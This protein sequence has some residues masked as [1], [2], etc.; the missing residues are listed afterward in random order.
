MKV[1]SCPNKSSK[2]FK[3]LNS[4]YGYAVTMQLYIANGEELPSLDEAEQMI[5]NDIVKKSYNLSNGMLINDIT[6]EMQGQVVRYLA[7]TM[8]T[9]IKDAKNSKQAG[10]YE[11]IAVDNLFN[12]FNVTKVLLENEGKTN[13]QKYR[14]ISS[15]VNN[16]NAFYRLSRFY[17]QSNLD[18]NYSHE[19]V[20]DYL[21]INSEEEVYEE[22]G[23]RLDAR[24]YGT[25]AFKEFLSFI[26]YGKTFFGTQDYLDSD[27]I[28]NELKQ[29]CA[30]VPND[31]RQ[32]IKALDNHSITHPYVKTIK[33]A[34]ATSPKHIKNQFVSLI[35]GHTIKM[36]MVSYKHIWKDGIPH[37]I[38][39]VYDSNRTKSFK[40][41]ANN[42]LNQLYTNGNTRRNNKK[43]RRYFTKEARE[44]LI[45]L[46]GAPREVKD[47]KTLDSILKIIGIDLR[48]TTLLDISE[49][50]IKGIKYPL[51]FNNNAPIGQLLQSLKVIAENNLSIE[52]SNLYSNFTINDLA[53]IE[54]RYNRTGYTETFTDSEGNLIQGFGLQKFLTQRLL[55]LK[56]NPNEVEEYLTPFNSTSDILSQL[57]YS[58][59]NSISIEADTI[60]LSYADGINNFDSNRS[61]TKLKK[62]DSADYEKYALGLFFNNNKKVKG[63]K[64]VE[65]LLPPFS[66]K[67]NMLKLQRIKEDVTLVNSQTQKGIYIAA[68]KDIATTIANSISEQTL[69]MLINKIFM[70]EYLRMVAAADENTDIKAFEAGKNIFYFIP[71]LNTAPYRNIIFDE[72]GEV[73]TNLNEEITFTFPGR[74]EEKGTRLEFV[75]RIV[76]GMMKQAVKEKL[77][78]WNDMGITNKNKLFTE[79]NYFNELKNVPDVLQ[80]GYLAL[81]YEIANMISNVE[82]FQ[83]FAGDPALYYKKDVDNTIDNIYKRLSGLIAPGISG[84]YESKPTVKTFFTQ[85]RKIKSQAYE[86]IK[87]V[88]GEEDAMPYFEIESTDSHELTTLEEHIDMLHMLGRIDDNIYNSIKTKIQTNRGGDYKL[89]PEEIKAALVP[90]K[91]VMFTKKVYKT[92]NEKLITEEVHYI[93]SSRFPLIPQLTKGF[94]IDK[95]RIAMEKTKIDTLVYESGHKLGNKSMVFSIFDENGDITESVDY[96]ESAM[97]IE[98]IDLDRQGLRIQQE[99]PIKEDIDSATRGTQEGKLLFAYARNL[100]NFKN[101]KTGRQLEKEYDELYGKLFKLKLKKLKESLGINQVG[102]NINIE[103]LQNILFDLAI[104]RGF[105]TAEIEALSLNKNGTDFKIPF[106]SLS[107]VNKYEELLNSIISNKLIKLKM[108]G[109]SYVLGPGAGWKVKGGSALR[110]KELGVITTDSYNEE[111]GLQPM[112]EDPKTGEILP[113]QIIIPF[114]YKKGK[115]S[116]Y[117]KEVN[118]RK[119]I[120]TSKLP[121]ELLKIFGFR[122]PSSKHSSFNYLEVVGFFPES[123]TQTIIDN[124]VLIPDDIVP[125]TGA[126][127]DVDK[128]FSYM[129]K[130]KEVDGVFVKDDNEESVIKNRLLDI[131]FEVMS[132][133]DMQKHI[134]KTVATDI[135]EKIADEIEKNSNKKKHPA[136]SFLTSEYNKNKFLNSRSAK[137]G[138]GVFSNDV[139]FHSTVVEKETKNKDRI[140]LRRFEEVKG[141]VVEVDYYINFGTEKG[142]YLDNATTLDGTL[143]IAEVH[144]QFQNIALDDENIGAVKKINISSYTF[145][146]I[147]LL[148]QLGFN[149]ETTLYFINQPIIKDYIDSLIKYKFK[150]DTEETSSQKAYKDIVNKYSYKENEQPAKTIIDYVGKNELK[151]LLNSREKANFLYDNSADY[152]YIQHLILDKFIELSNV[153]LQLKTIKSTINTDSARIKGST[154]LAESKLE[155]VVKLKSLSNIVN[156]DRIIGEYLNLNSPVDSKKYYGT[157]NKNE[158]FKIPYNGTTYAIKPNTLIGYATMYGLTTALDLWVINSKYFNPKQSKIVNEKINKVLEISGQ[159]T[160]DHYNRAA[161]KESVWN[162]IKSSVYSTLFV[163]LQLEGKSLT[164]IR[165]ELFVDEIVEEDEAVTIYNESLATIFSKIRSYEQFQNN[166]FIQ[167]LYPSND[168][169]IAGEA[170]TVLKYNASSKQRNYE[171]QLVADFLDLLQNPK[172]IGKFMIDGKVINYTTRDFVEKFILSQY[173]KGGLQQAGEF[174]KYI[175]I[176]L[177]E[178]MGYVEALED[179]DLFKYIPETSIRFGKEYLGSTEVQYM[180][181]NP[182]LAT[183]LT[184]NLEKLSNLIGKTVEDINELHVI[185]IPNDEETILANGLKRVYRSFESPVE[186]SLF[187]RI[188]NDEASKGYSLFMLQKVDN[189]LTYVRIPVLGTKDIT[190]TNNKV[191]IGD[192]IN[193]LKYPTPYENEVEARELEKAIVENDV[194]VSFNDIY[195]IKGKQNDIFNN[196]LK[197]IGNQTTNNKFKYLSNLILSIKDKIEIPKIEIDNS[198]GHRGEYDSNTNIIKINTSLIKTQ[199]EFEQVVLEEIIHSIT[200]QNIKDGGENYLKL[201]ELRNTIINM[202]GKDKVAKVAEKI[203]NGKPL[204]QEEVDLYYPLTDMYEFVAAIFTNPKFQDYLHSKEYQTDKSL[205]QR[206]RDIILNILKALGVKQNTML[207]AAIIEATPLILSPKN[208]KGKNNPVN[209]SPQIKQKYT[210]EQLNKHFKLTTRNGGKKIVSRPYSVASWINENV[211]NVYAS[212]H[213]DGRGQIVV[214]TYTSDKNLS[215]AIADSENDYDN[216]IEFDYNN[217]DDFFGFDENLVTEEEEELPIGDKLRR[218]KLLQ[219]TRSKIKKLEIQLANAE[220]DNDFEKAEEINSKISTLQSYLEPLTELEI[221]QIRLFANRDLREI[222]D[223]LMRPKL[224]V[225]NILYIGDIID[226]WKNA[227]HLLLTAEEREIDELYKQFQKFEADF[228]RYENSI[229][230]LQEKF[231]NSYIKNTTGKE[232][233]INEVF[234]Y[235]KDVDSITGAN[236]DISRI[237]NPL[238]QTL[239]QNVK[240]EN[241]RARQ[242]A[243]KENE[244]TDNLHKEAQK[245]AR[246]LGIDLNDLFSQKDKYGRKTGELVSVYNNNWYDKIAQE[247]NYF[248]KAEPKDTEKAV[249]RYTTFLMRNTIV[250]DTRLLFPDEISTQYFDGDLEAEKKKHIEEVISIIGE[251]E[252]NVLYSSL[253]KK[254]KKYLNDLEI[255]K[256]RI[257]IKVTEKITSTLGSIEENQLA[258]EEEYNKT[259][260]R[261]LQTFSPHAYSRSVNNGVVL[262]YNHKGQ[263]YYRKVKGD[264]YTITIPRKNVRLRPP[265]GI[266]TNVEERTSNP[267]Q[268]IGRAEYGEST[269]FYDDSFNQ[270]KD[271]EAI[272]AYYQRVVEVLSQMRLYLPESERI[273]MDENT[274]PRIYKDVMTKFMQN[275]SMAGVHGIWDAVS[276]SFGS[277]QDN[278]IT[279]TTK[280]VVTDEDELSHKPKYLKNDLKDLNLYIDVAINEAQ[281]KLGRKLTLEE[282]DDIKSKAREE[283]TNKYAMDI[284]QIIQMYTASTIAYKHKI[285]TQDQV[286]IARNILYRMKE[287]KTTTDGQFVVSADSRDYDKKNTAESFTGMKLSFDAFYKSFYGDTRDK[288]KSFD[289]KTYTIK[290]RKL[291]SQ[292]GKLLKSLEKSYEDGEIDEEKYTEKKEQIENRLKNIGKVITTATLTDSIITY[293]QLKGMGWNFYS[294]ISNM[295]FGLIS[296]LIESGDG[297]LYGFKDL[298][299]ANTIVLGSITKNLSF[300]TLNLGYAAKVRALMDKFDVLKDASNELYT[301]GKGNFLTTKLKFLSPYQLQ[302]RSEYL[303]QAP[304]LVAMM[305]KQQ[306]TDVN[307]NSRSLWEAY[308][309]DGNWK[310]DEFGE[311]QEWNGDFNRKDNNTKYLKFKN[312]VDQVIKRNHGNYDP[313]SPIYSKRSSIGRLLIQFKTW[314]LEGFANRF[315]GEKYD[316]VLEI[317]RR[318]RYRDF[319]KV[320]SKFQI[321]K[322]INHT[323]LAMVNKEQLLKK[324]GID[325]TYVA[326][327]RKNFIELVIWSSIAALLLMLS[328]ALDDEDDDE[329]KFYYTFLINQFLRLQTDIEL[330][331]SPNA[332]Y[333]LVKQPIAATRLI[334]EI[335]ELGTA[336]YK[337]AIGE[338]E[339]NGGIYDGDSRAIREILQSLPFGNQVYRNYVAGKSVFKN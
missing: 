100:T 202:V 327:F 208:S 331:F 317:N 120:D 177:L 203:K 217:T 25:R 329:K 138:V 293:I 98:A 1:N 37:H 204:T 232:T 122:I 47:I 71:V 3:E 281:K 123:G 75:K 92:S 334:I 32:I 291:K 206:F 221:D 84:N 11:K 290:E 278:E 8:Y 34:L 323:Y 87:S 211:E 224:S 205:I 101:K 61:G 198:I 175:P 13:T 50:G 46:I 197:S 18:V 136:Y 313:D 228:A 4:K 117:I 276:N 53:K 258:Y 73:S 129:Y 268:Y 161:N 274:L 328:S 36:S 44:K 215:P 311:N 147:S 238:L 250:L 67:P 131:R 245:E 260:Q 289:R 310:T 216:T 42:W 65:T 156:A 88:L 176:E 145:D 57:R 265:K 63:R 222:R 272:Y 152:N 270:I 188:A 298:M 166:S 140:K 27:S 157:K 302:K 119:V 286:N 212:V 93:K 29:M 155:N 137:V 301:S 103:K 28:W 102:D 17:L 97:Q 109:N 158:Y 280:N 193:E 171:S 7:H 39:R 178:Q 320:A 95:V 247:R 159:N 314:M 201:L 248:D 239:Y 242:I 108:T 48:E 251:K 96:L 199:E 173:L 85:D 78:A 126:D 130:L 76:I 107:S 230:K 77:K 192:S 16:K 132:H 51:Q 80:L 318:G 180:Q 308:D 299:K 210:I 83:V 194:E 336:I 307:G 81:D 62:S 330:Y 292:L 12:K 240:S 35:S 121:K 255:A 5:N 226:L 94:D 112:R 273:K 263:K 113:A 41:I 196:I 195:N 261:W 295:G 241:E 164:D 114:V 59:P 262:T 70:P 127:F 220:N 91:P 106:W 124:L 30:D 305:L 79:I 2:E 60:E 235:Q 288:E 68:N 306:I 149:P 315:E 43:S 279:Y 6:S 252:Y 296:N 162:F 300:N 172:T 229:M 104:E 282:E 335:G 337:A 20:I 69:K 26:P 133:P 33:H 139:V 254:Y 322:F 141:K 125:Q 284:N 135:I 31:Y 297:R 266:N 49:R 185:Q 110:V 150:S 128:L 153:G 182:H 146:V 233:D 134:L 56:N 326:N 283:L 45:D 264:K 179:V 21:E 259:L 115:L 183:R 321:G 324:E 200:H 58:D 99:N 231:I 267:T 169:T 22:R 236:L 249:K 116:N 237:N 24:N 66:N 269:G 338:D 105:T 111:K 89:K 213:N 163:D 23:L 191:L 40:I 214:L 277:A 304:V 14:V 154:F 160:T 9:A 253:E 333:S 15:I 285:A 148:N 309:K 319:W 174:I 144:S 312:K 19:A 74:T 54:S 52:E 246:S 82:F 275:G 184:N 207:E 234:L 86:Y 227:T 303:N 10:A 339:I 287:T 167:A 170:T 257:R 325:E 168:T 64:V 316:D 256:E 186:V 143:E 72:N 223:L 218:G 90:V 38:T 294:A 190:E 243:I 165:K 151:D 219:F 142:L 332:L 189:N 55:H 244:I 181:H 271:N 225:A 209:N 187:L 118:G